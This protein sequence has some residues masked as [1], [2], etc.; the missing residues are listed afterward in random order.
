MGRSRTHASE[1]SLASSRPA[2]NG[3]PAAE[4]AQEAGLVYTTDDEPGIRRVRKGKNSFD[5]L[6]PD[7]RR[8]VT[9]S[10]STLVSADFAPVL[11]PARVIRAFAVD[12]MIGVRAE[13]VAQ[14]LDEVCGTPCASVSVVVGKR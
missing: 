2:A 7:G 4:A 9:R 8:S 5:Y 3:D 14:S 6:G 11:R 13:V 10:S 12:A 1:R